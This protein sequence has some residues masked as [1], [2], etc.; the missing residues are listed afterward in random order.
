MTWKGNAPVVRLL[1]TIY[2]TGVRLSKQA[3][4]EVEKHLERLSDLERWFVKIAC[5]LFS[6]TDT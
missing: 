5:T 2:E 4:A 6:E 3:M 1:T